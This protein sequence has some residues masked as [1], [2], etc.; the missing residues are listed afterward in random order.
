MALQSSAMVS[1]TYNPN[2]AAL[3]QIYV[4]VLPQRRISSK[5]RD[6]TGPGSYTSYQYSRNSTDWNVYILAPFIGVALLLSPTR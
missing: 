2:M 4:G 1:Q 3:I 6:S 5:L